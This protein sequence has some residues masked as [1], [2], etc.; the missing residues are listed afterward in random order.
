MRIIMVTIFAAFVFAIGAA[1]V[2]ANSLN[3]SGK[4]FDKGAGEVIELQGSSDEPS[5]GVRCGAKSSDTSGSG[6]DPSIRLAAEMEECPSGSGKRCPVG[7]RCYC[8]SK[9][10]F[11]VSKPPWK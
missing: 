2:Q 10:C 6:N 4:A 3:P 5:P 1:P 9:G 11:C 8:D 7:T